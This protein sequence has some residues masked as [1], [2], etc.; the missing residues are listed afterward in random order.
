MVAVNGN[1]VGQATLTELKGIL[2]ASQ[3]FVNLTTK[4]NDALY[5]AYVCHASSSSP[6]SSPLPFPVSPSR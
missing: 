2:E 3:E 1:D 5:A 4:P 6:S